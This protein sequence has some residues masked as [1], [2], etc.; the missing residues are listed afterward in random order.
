MGI[1]ACPGVMWCYTAHFLLKRVKSSFEFED[2]GLG[3]PGPA[4]GSCS[5]SLGTC[6]YTII[7]RAGAQKQTEGHAA[8]TNLTY[9]SA[10]RGVQRSNRSVGGELEN[11]VDTK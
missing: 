5:E 3:A 6:M 9:F 11:P 8:A 10:A 1:K 7:C 4:P 2:E